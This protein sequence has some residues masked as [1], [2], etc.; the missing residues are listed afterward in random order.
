MRIYTFPE[1]ILRER[2]PD[3]DFENPVMDPKELEK[4]LKTYVYPY[5]SGY[6]EVMIKEMKNTIDMFLK[7][8]QYNYKLL[9]IHRLIADSATK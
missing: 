3:F 6:F 5:Y 7:S 2:M 1:P 4:M 9:K 8:I